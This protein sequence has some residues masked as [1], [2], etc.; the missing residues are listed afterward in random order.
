MLCNVFNPPKQTQTMGSAF[1]RIILYV[2][3]ATVLLSCLKYLNSCLQPQPILVSWARSSLLSNLVLVRFCLILRWR[4]ACMSKLRRQVHTE[5]VTSANICSL[6]F[7]STK[8]NQQFKSGFVLL[9]LIFRR[10][11]KTL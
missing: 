2:I 8:Y 9:P 6:V 11:Y 4:L 1:G 10:I 3:W 7:L 5:F